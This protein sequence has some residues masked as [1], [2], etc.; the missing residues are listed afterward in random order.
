[1]GITEK[2]RKHNPGNIAIL[3]PTRGLKAEHCSSA[4]PHPPGVSDPDLKNRQKG[5]RQGTKR[6]RR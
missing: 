3:A 6:G 2:R 1:M 4:A 5:T